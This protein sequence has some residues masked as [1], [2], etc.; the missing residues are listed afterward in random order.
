[1]HKGSAWRRA[2]A[3]MPTEDTLLGALFQRREPQGGRP[4]LR[5]RTTTPPD[6][7]PRRLRP[8]AGRDVLGSNAG[9]RPCARAGRSDRSAARWVG[10]RVAPGKSWEAAEEVEPRRGHKPMEGTSDPGARKG[11]GRNGPVRRATPRSRGFLLADTSTAD[12]QREADPG[13]PSGKDSTARG[14][15]AVVTPYGYERG[16]LFE[17]SWRREERGLSHPGSM[18]T[19]S[20]ASL[21]RPKGAGF[22]KRGEPQDRQRDATS[23]RLR[24]RRKPS[25]WCETTRTERGWTGGAVGPRLFGATGIGSREGPG[26]GVDA[27]GACRWRGEQVTNPRRGRVPVSRFGASASE[28]FSPRGTR[29]LCGRFEGEGN[30]HGVPTKDGSPSRSDIS[31]KSSRAPGW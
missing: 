26:P 21:S 10:P 16:E 23:P 8:N 3:R 28:R 13:C 1:M 22:T 15:Q 18:E 7:L 11:A 5:T 12:R 20:V 19:T 24:V 17:G 4:R 9:I 27:H 25:R 2:D 29:Q 6:R 14:H 30:G 31:V